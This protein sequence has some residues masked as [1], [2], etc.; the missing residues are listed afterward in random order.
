[1][2]GEPLWRSPINPAEEVRMYARDLQEGFYDP[3]LGEI[4]GQDTVCWQYNF[5]FGEDEAFRQ[6]KDTIYW[7]GVDA[8]YEEP[9]LWAWGWKTTNPMETPH[10][11]DD[12][13]YIDIFP[14]GT[15]VTPA[16]LRYP[17]GHPF[18]GES[19]DL[20][21]VITPEPATLA[22]MGLGLAGVM[23]SRR[24]KT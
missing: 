16:E 24:R 17:L 11:N 22:L 23:A 21:F 15:S 13:V 19:M 12:A 4:V 9:E 3:N 20:A 2:P 7:L 5:Y 6:E 10:F 8:Y 14:D 1:M 18:E